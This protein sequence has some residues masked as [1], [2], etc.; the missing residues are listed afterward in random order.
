MADFNSSI[1]ILI[2]PKDC[3]LQGY[4]VCQ[5]DIA[6]DGAGVPSHGGR[7]L[8]SSIAKT[9]PEDQVCCTLAF[10][11]LHASSNSKQIRIH[12]RTGTNSAPRSAVQPMRINIKWS[13]M[14]EYGGD[15]EHRHRWRWRAAEGE[16]SD[17]LHSSVAKTTPVNQ[18]VVDD[19]VRQQFGTSPSIALTLAYRRMEVEIFD[20]L[21][22]Q[23][24]PRE[25]DD[26]LWHNPRASSRWRKIRLVENASSPSVVKTTP[27][28]QAIVHGTVHVASVFQGHRPEAKAKWSSIRWVQHRLLI[29]RWGEEMLKDWIVRQWNTSSIALAYVRID[30]EAFDLLD[31]QGDARAP[32]GSQWR[33][34]GHRYG[35]RRPEYTDDHDTASVVGEK[36]KWS[37]ISVNPLTWGTSL[38]KTSREVLMGLT[39]KIG[40]VI[41]WRNPARAQRPQSTRWPSAHT[42]GRVAHIGKAKK[43]GPWC[44]RLVEGNTLVP[45]ISVPT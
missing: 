16:T 17:L 32:G 29:S 18:V 15:L 3:A 2:N 12:S 24:D 7:D 41:V 27:K 9:T 37:S 10:T 5:P 30:V 6:I 26:R 28:N 45:M 43:V 42:M 22:S 31:S 36:G 25:P 34:G 20:L 38:V 39:F 8:R 19:R 11:L 35:H 21:D 44:R 1:S 40:F 23:D 14:I 4:V 13:S 33:S